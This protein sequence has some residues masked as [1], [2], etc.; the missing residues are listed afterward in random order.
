M[1]SKLPPENRFMGEITRMENEASAREHNEE[2]IPVRLRGLAYLGIQYDQG[3][4]TGVD[5]GS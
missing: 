5:W 3:R 2:R 4:A 1:T